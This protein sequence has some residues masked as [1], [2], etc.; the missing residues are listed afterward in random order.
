MKF[1]GPIPKTSPMKNWVFRQK[2]KF[3][4][5]YLVLVSSNKTEQKQLIW[6][7]FKQNSLALQSW[8]QGYFNSGS[9]INLHKS[10]DWLSSKLFSCNNSNK[11]PML[12]RK[13]GENRIEIEDFFK[14]IYWIAARRRVL[15][16]H[17]STRMTSVHTSGHANSTHERQWK[18]QCTTR[19][20]WLECET[21]WPTLLQD[22]PESLKHDY[23]LF[24]AFTLQYFCGY[25]CSLT[26][27]M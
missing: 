8:F 20:R 1:L 9:T 2:H 14:E 15:T 25:F 27:K 21:L 11:T 6:C 13:N 26:W 16:V 4:Q 3:L 5:M 22:P 19:S 23:Y 24:N 10:E 7:F 17:P 18:V 12:Q